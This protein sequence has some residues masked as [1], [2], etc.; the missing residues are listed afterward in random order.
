MDLLSGYSVIGRD[1]DS[2]EASVNK[3]D[4]ILFLCTAGAVSGDLGRSKWKP[5]LF[6]VAMSRE[7]T[8]P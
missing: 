7:E 8:G 4:R 1:L 3:A 5:G 6:Q 2:K